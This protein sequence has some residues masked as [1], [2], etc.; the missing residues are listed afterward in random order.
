MTIGG[1]TNRALFE[2]NPVVSDLVISLSYVAILG[3]LGFYALADFLRANRA[4]RLGTTPRWMTEL[5]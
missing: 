3:F 4:A 2:Q 5:R 1:A